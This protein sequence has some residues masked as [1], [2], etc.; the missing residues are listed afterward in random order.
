VTAV[1]YRIPVVNK[2]EG[3]TRLEDLDL[4]ALLLHSGAVQPVD[5]AHLVARSAAGES[6]CVQWLPS[7]DLS[8]VPKQRRGTL[9]IEAA[10]KGGERVD[11]YVRTGVAASAKRQ[12]GKEG[13]E[14]RETAEA[15]EIA[16]DGKPFVTYRY[17][18]KDPLLAV[19]VLDALLPGKG[20]LITNSAGTENP[21]DGVAA[22]WI[23]ISGRMNDAWQGVALFNHS[24]NFRDPTPCLQFSRQT[25][26]LAP[27]HRDPHTLEAGREL[28]LHFRVFV[29]A[30]TIKDA[31]VAAQ[32]Q[33]Y[34]KPAQT[35]IGGPERISG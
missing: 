20:G 16:S 25:I 1:S 30:G 18:M 4:S 13:V 6:L 2:T 33:A 21:A 23:D 32:Y 29:H 28:R 5:F 3:A 11:L 35:R 24:G 22:H 26:G 7:A 12:A 15:L 27:T 17:N 14:V 9:L 8:A 34:I 19:R 31:G 10:K